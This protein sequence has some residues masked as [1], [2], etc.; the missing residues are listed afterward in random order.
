VKSYADSSFV[1][2]L[3]TPDTNSPAA[4]ARMK[5][6][7]RPL[8]LTGLHRLEFRNA[9]RLRVFRGEITAEERESSIQAMLADFAADVFVFAEMRWPELLLEA[10]RLS[11]THSEVLGTRS[12]DILH[13]ASALLL[14]AQEF[15]TFDHRQSALAA[16]VGLIV[17]RL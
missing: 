14:G 8:I 4:I 3:Y 11:A 17:A 16:A 10:E 6:Q 9:L 2:S 13:V 12:L 5:R 7:R 15:M 1:C